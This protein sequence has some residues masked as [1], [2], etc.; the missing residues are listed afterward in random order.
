MRSPG[1]EMCCA[2][3]FTYMVS[4]GEALHLVRSTSCM[5]LFKSPVLASFK[6][7]SLQQLQPWFICLKTLQWQSCRLAMAMM[8]SQGTATATSTYPGLIYRGSCPITPH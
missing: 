8:L 6:C 3:A 7:I 5:Y 4:A 1:I 2:N